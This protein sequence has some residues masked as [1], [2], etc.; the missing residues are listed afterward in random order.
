VTV[1]YSGDEGLAAAGRSEFDV[2]VL[3]MRMPGRDGVATLRAIRECGDQTPV[4]LLSACA[5][6]EAAVAALALGASDYLV[7][8]CPI[9]ALHAA[10]LDAWERKEALSQT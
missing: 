9:D 2:I 3:D 6:V 5:E 10:I 4:L 8:P 7:K 1:A